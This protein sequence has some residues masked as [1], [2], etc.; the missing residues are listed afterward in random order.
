MSRPLSGAHLLKTGLHDNAAI[1][2]DSSDTEKLLKSVLITQPFTSGA[3][4]G[5]EGG[6]SVTIAGEDLSALIIERVEAMLKELPEF[7][8]ETNISAKFPLKYDDS[9]TTIL[10]LETTRCNKL[11][12]TI[13][14]S[15][16]ELSAALKG[17]L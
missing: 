4:G 13:H 2:K 15:L 7:F 3:V 5:S 10:R 11:L 8:D 1:C 16:S 17:E 12:G 6:A 14:S 9:M